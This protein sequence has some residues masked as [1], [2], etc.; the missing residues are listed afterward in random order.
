MSTPKLSIF[1]INYKVRELL[2]ENLRA[3][4]A[5]SFFNELEIIVVDNGSNDGVGKMIREEFPGTILILNDY[6]SGSSHAV[7]Q[8]LRVATGEVLLWLNPDMKVHPGCLQKTHDT[9]IADKTIGL[10]GA[11][12]IDASGKP[13]GSVRR[14]PSFLDQLAI[15]LKLPHLFPHL[16]NRYLYKEFDYEISQEVPQIRGSYFAFRLDVMEQVGGFDESFFIWFE[17]VD[18]CRRVRQV[19]YRIYY[20]A[21]ALCEDLVGQSFRQVCV[22]KKQRL[23]MRSL[24]T[25]FDKWHPWWQARI[26]WCF[27]PFAIGA[28]IIID[29]FSWLRKKFV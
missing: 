25:Y 1:I 23:L 26:L 17:E 15:V 10:F 19:G 5:D 21:E 3:L 24:V 20:C 9:L 4:H 6:N 13:I 22:R 14:D 2:R 7:N 27:T 12:L 18:Y 11:K 16:F 29:F 8:A 28:G